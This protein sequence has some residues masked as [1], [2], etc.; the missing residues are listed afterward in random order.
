MTP[1]PHV[2]A[3]QL[4]LQAFGK[5]LLLAAPSSHC[6]VAGERTPS[7]HPAGGGALDT[8]PGE[9]AP[10]GST[11]P[12]GEAAPGETAPGGETAEPAAPE[13]AGLGATGVTELLPGTDTTPLTLA[14]PGLSGLSA[15][16]C[17]SMNLGF[18][19][20]HPIKQNP[21]PALTK[22]DHNTLLRRFMRPNVRGIHRRRLHV[23]DFAPSDAV[24]R[25]KSRRTKR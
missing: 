2:H 21:R 23:L 5:T 14:E 7:P 10:G 18:S 25:R 4:V 15:P 20:E 9:T 22:P 24:D 16:G 11:A 8:A 17:G 6:S 3:V 19:A 12:G 1:S 13:D